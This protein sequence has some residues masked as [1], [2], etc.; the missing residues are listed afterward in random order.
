MDVTYLWITKEY[1]LYICKLM[2][3]APSGWFVSAFPPIF[4]VGC[5]VC[6]VHVGSLD[7]LSVQTRRLRFSCSPFLCVS[8][9]SEAQSWYTLW[10]LCQEVWL[11]WWN[12]K[13]RIFKHESG[14]ENRNG[15]SNRKRVL[16]NKL[17]NNKLLVSTD[18]VSRRAAEDLIKTHAEDLC[19]VF[20]RN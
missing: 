7:A 19:C 15:E 3:N 1:N 14:A 17:T 12:S 5:C 16:V 4:N 11:V 18:V 6:S 10:V 13:V 20:W 8:N 2:Q 9:E